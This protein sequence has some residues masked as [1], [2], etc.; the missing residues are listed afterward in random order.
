LF[1]QKVPLSAPAG[2]SVLGTDA[3]W[4]VERPAVGHSLAT[5]PSYS[6][7]DFT[8]AAAWSQLAGAANANL[9]FESFALRSGF[10]VPVGV[11]AV[12]ASLDF[13]PPISLR[14]MVSETGVIFAG[15]GQTIPMDENGS[16]I[17]VADIQGKDSLRC[18]YVGLQPGNLGLGGPPLNLQTG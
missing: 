12:A 5:L 11:R 8:Y 16:P 13:T 14:T 6:P 2:V 7:V 10:A 18:E 17:S 15:S 4:I 9:S 3:E 1:S